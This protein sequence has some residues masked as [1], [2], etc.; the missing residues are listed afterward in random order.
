MAW[1]FWGQQRDVLLRTEAHP[2]TGDKVSFSQSHVRTIEGLW[3]KRIHLLTRNS[4]TCSPF[5]FR[6]LNWNSVR[7]NINPEGYTSHRHIFYTCNMENVLGL[8]EIKW[9]LPM[10]ALPV[11]WALL[12]QHQGCPS[13]IPP[14]QQAGGGSQGSWSKLTKGS[15]AFNKLLWS[16]PTNLFHLLF[17]P[18]P[19][20]PEEWQNSAKARPPQVPDWNRTRNPHE[21]RTWHNRFVL[22]RTNH[23]DRS[24]YSGL[25]YYLFDCHIIAH[26]EGC[27]ALKSNRI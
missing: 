4:W 13:N 11:L 26:T 24:L 23:K 22:L 12:S 27:W 8:V 5:S 14:L 6:P 10:P 9:I 1:L 20:P 3:T 7:S 15:F 21:F 25:L 18:P 19:H 2:D 16:W 17:L